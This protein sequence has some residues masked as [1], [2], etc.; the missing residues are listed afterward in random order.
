MHTAF[1]PALSLITFVRLLRSNLKPFL[2]ASHGKLLS[3]WQPSPMS[4]PHGYGCLIHMHKTYSRNFW[5]FTQ[6]Y[7]H[8]EGKEYRPSIPCCLLHHL[9][10][11]RLLWS[12]CLQAALQLLQNSHQTF[13]LQM[14]STAICQSE[15]KHEL[16]TIE[17]VLMFC[18]KSHVELNPAK[19]MQEPQ[20][21][22]KGSA[23]IAD[24]PHICMQ[25]LLLA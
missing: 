24:C 6:I 2:G 1:A 13:T 20:V 7:K 19:P 23:D 25:E 4:I 8:W 12:H 10:W 3:C 16:P 9:W 11:H 18:T 22:S 21:L 17:K 5:Y 15:R 14:K